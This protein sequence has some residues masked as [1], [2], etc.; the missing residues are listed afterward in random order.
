MPIVSA[1]TRHALPIGVS[2]SIT[3]VGVAGGAAVHSTQQG[4]Q[5]AY[6]HLLYERRPIFPEIPPLKDLKKKKTEGTR[7]CRLFI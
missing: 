5:V 2:F 3:G 4:A 1:L 6:R 7:Y